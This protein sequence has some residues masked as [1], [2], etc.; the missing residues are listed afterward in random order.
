MFWPGGVVL[1]ACL[2]CG[3]EA[4]ALALRSGAH[5]LLWLLWWQDS[6][7]LLPGHGGILDRVDS[8]LLA[9]PAFFYLHFHPAT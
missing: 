3:P 4:N 6:G 5:G 8:L 9:A 2:G 1:V 7:R